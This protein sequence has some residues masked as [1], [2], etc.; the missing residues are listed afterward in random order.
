MQLCGAI[1]AE[2]WL[3]TWRNSQ[4][5][6]PYEVYAI[7]YGHHERR[8]SLNFL[9]GDP[10]D[11]PMPLD[12]FVWLIRGNGINIVVDTGYDEEMAKRRKHEFI[13][14]PEVGLQML[15]VDHQQIEDVIMTHIHHDHAGNHHL[16]PNATFHVQD[17]EMSFATGRGMC[18]HALRAPYDR[19][20][21]VQMVRRL[22]NGK[23]RFHDGV[24]DIAPGISVHHMG[25]H[26][27][28]MQCVRIL[29]RRGY[30]VLASDVSHFYTNFQEERPFPVLH[31]VFASVEAYRRLREL[32]STE[33]LIVPGHDPLV[34]KR[35]PWALSDFEG[36]VRLDA[37]QIPQ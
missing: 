3:D 32:A 34:L 35:F 25:G 14:K 24:Q 16:F 5:M 12:Y 33:D 21:V 26:T 36:I 1:D 20:D 2:S 15:G 29:T 27:A 4:E 37:D 31:D 18:H 19:E 7:R 30:M 6:D 22:F 9:G 10:H 23:V 28:G 17:S 11:G 13:L 8:A